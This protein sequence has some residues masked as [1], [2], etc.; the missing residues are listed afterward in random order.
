MLWLYLYLIIKQ[1]ISCCH[2]GWKDF[3][4]CHVDWPFLLPKVFRSLLMYLWS[5]VSLSSMLNVTAS[6]LL[7]ILFDYSARDTVYWIQLLPLNPE[8]VFSM[9][10]NSAVIGVG[11]MICFGCSIWPQDWS[12]LNIH[13]F[14]KVICIFCSILGWNQFY[15][16]GSTLTLLRVL[17][18]IRLYKPSSNPQHPRV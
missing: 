12:L 14:R 8:F 5:V 4:C 16:V 11:S 15:G 7:L 2:A 9:K 17:F 18:V 1:K 6:W 10:S 13:D 3:S